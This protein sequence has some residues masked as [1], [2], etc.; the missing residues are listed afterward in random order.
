MS[1]LARQETGGSLPSG[2]QLPPSFNISAP[3]IILPISTIPG[4][5]SSLI[6]ISTATTSTFSTTS[7]QTVST[8]TSTFITQT[9]P[10][11]VIPT[12]S[13]TAQQTAIKSNASLTKTNTIIIGALCGFTLLLIL[14]LGLFAF[15]WIRRLRRGRGRQENS[16]PL[17]SLAAGVSRPS[18]SQQRPDQAASSPLDLREALSSHPPNPNRISFSR[19][20]SPAGFHVE[21]FQSQPSPQSIPLPVINV[22]PN[23]P[24]VVARD[25][26]FPVS[27]IL[28]AS[29]ARTPLYETPSQ[30]DTAEGSARL[31]L[32]VPELEAQRAS[33]SSVGSEYEDGL[34]QANTPERVAGVLPSTRA[35][36][37]VFP[38]SS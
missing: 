1:V 31:G 26:D 2:L 36:S 32:P 9:L 29:P 23:T 30:E 18:K 17:T 21:A 10:V 34:T 25:E 20:F 37:G 28:Q 11:T 13:L 15:V 19:P 22:Q 4:P 5:A 27:P 35:S 24:S 6:T 3:F 16:P 14:A 7:Y 8:T 38:E 12:A 33:V